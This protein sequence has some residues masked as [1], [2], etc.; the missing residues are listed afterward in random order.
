MRYVACNF[1][2]D[3]DRILIW[4]CN[5]IVGRLVDLRIFLIDLM[6]SKAK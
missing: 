2:D 3:I 5:R 4:C 1:G 6:I